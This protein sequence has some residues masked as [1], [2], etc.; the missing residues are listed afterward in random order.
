M[1]EP[2]SGVRRT[3]SPVDT[4]SEVKTRPQHLAMA[5]QGQPLATPYEGQGTAS[6]ESSVLPTL[7]LL[8]PGP[9]TPGAD[10]RY[11]RKPRPVCGSSSRRFRR[12]ERLLLSDNCDDWAYQERLSEHGRRCN[13]GSVDRP[14]VGCVKVS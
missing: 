14:C 12:P 11:A 5:R 13:S 4:P 9:S 8:P 2:E 3:G 10:R 1:T 6:A 7:P